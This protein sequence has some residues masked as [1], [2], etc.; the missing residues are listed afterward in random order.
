MSCCSSITLL[1][2]S[3]SA[4]DDIANATKVKAALAT[5]STLRDEKIRSGLEQLQP[6]FTWAKVCKLPDRAGSLL[7]LTMGTHS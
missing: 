5:L 4:S 2:G 7:S 3:C 6:G 1:I